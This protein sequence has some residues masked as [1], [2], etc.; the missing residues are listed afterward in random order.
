VVS[1]T[2]SFGKRAVTAPPPARAQTAP[3]AVTDSIPSP[4]PVSGLTRTLSRLPYFTV[5]LSLALI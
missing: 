1:R 2:T 5:V 4:V 3:A